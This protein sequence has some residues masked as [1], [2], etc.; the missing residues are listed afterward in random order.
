MTEE[1]SSDLSAD[2]NYVKVLDKG[3][4]RFIDVMGDDSAIVQAARTSYGKGTKSVTEDRALIRY[5]VRNHHTSPLEMVEFKFH[6]KLPIFVMRQHVRH[7]TAN[8]NEY[9]GRYSVM[10]DEF[11]IP[12]PDRLQSQSVVNKQGSGGALGGAE[13][14]AVHELIKHMSAESY[15][16]YLALINDPQSADYWPIDGRQGLSRELS[17]IILPQNNY[18][19]CYWKIDLKNLLHYIRLRADSHAQWEIQE[20]A[21]ALGKFVQAQCP[22]AFEAFEDYMEHAVTLSRMDQVLLQDVIQHSNVNQLNFKQAYEMILNSFASKEEFIKSYRMS[23]REIT[24]F[25]VKW[26]IAAS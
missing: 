12:E 17:R 22:I 21:R 15:K 11:Y 7:R 24:E 1:S 26:Q 16:S 25:E 14:E 13:L 19:E 2:P 4:V 10:T 9:S 23:K 8:L 18:T 20:F 6:I 3:F 5:L